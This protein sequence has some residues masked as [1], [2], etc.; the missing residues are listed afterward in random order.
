MDY[1]VELSKHAADNLE[2][3]PRNIQKKFASM[4]KV[5]SKNLFP[6]GYKKMRGI[7][8]QYRI[9]FGKKYHIIYTFNP[10]NKLLYIVD[11][12]HR[13]DIYR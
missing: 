10:N 13:K 5:L 12:D 4:V 11:V 2:T 3:L 7:E 8:N 9:T 1:S 6:R